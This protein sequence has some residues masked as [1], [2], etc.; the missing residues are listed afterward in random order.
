[1]RDYV[2]FPRRVRYAA[3]LAAPL[4]QVSALGAAL[5]RDIGRHA[6]MTLALRAAFVGLEFLC[7]LSLAR[8]FGAASY[9]VYAF[10]ISCVALLGIPA[11]AGFDRLLIRELAAQCSRSEW[12][13]ARGIIRRSAQIVLAV[14]CAVAAMIALVTALFGSRYLGGPMALALELGMVVVPIVAY[15]RVRQA[16]LQGLG[17][18]V[19][20]QI[21]ETLVQPLAL[22]CGVG[23]VHWGVGGPRSGA[24]AVA[25][26]AASAILA[27]VVGIA[28]VQRVL[29]ASIRNADVAYRTQYWV[30]GALPFVW[31][32]GMNVILT[33]ADTVIVGLLSG[34][35]PA[36]VY[37]VSSQMAMLVALPL[38]AVNMAVAPSLAACYARGDR[39][40]MQLKAGAAARATVLVAVPVAVALLVLGKP[41]LGWF[42]RE[43]PAGFPSLAIL[44]MGYLVNA[45]TGT[46]GY[47]LIMTKYERAAARGF[48]CAAALNVCGCFL[49]VPLLGIAGA[50][51]ATALSVVALSVT[52]AVLVYRKL[53]IRSIVQP[54]VELP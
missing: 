36:A 50:A 35:T 38:T 16:V 23:L 19:L 30:R 41:V 11:A 7:G 54:A 34:P 33:Y 49:L 20:G 53:G 25:L 44:V 22:L 5:G 13:Y 6:A 43:F 9:G 48:A 14:S 8:V 51:G 10:V 3:V 17:R 29:P 32:L 47:L 27:C 37:R 21:P 40:A 4:R 46:S 12:P 31:M 1:M 45:S 42:G 2:R 52:F 28:I 39:S 15:A 18:V 24:L 26:N